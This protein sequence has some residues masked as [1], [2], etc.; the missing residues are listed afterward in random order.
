M[1]LRQ[2]WHIVWKRIWVVIVLVVV[3]GALSAATY[4]SPPTT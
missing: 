4:N 1:E 3:V 2:Y